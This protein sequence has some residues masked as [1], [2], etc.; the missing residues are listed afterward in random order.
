MKN[1]EKKKTLT[2][3][4]WNDHGKWDDYLNNKSETFKNLIK[5]RCDV[6][7]WKSISGNIS[8]TRDCVWRAFPNTERE[9]KIRRAAE[10]FPNEI[11]T[12]EKTEK[13][14]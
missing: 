10:Y 14:N 5:Q 6:V 3:F 2:N 8:N 12:E 7:N 1:T 13:T 11:K 9:L 4:L